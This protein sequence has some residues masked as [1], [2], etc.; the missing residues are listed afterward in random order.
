[1]LVVI[2]D[3]YETPQW[4]LESKWARESGD[5]AS[6]GYVKHSSFVALS[7]HTFLIEPSGFWNL[8]KWGTLARAHTHT[9]TMMSW[10]M[11]L[12][13]ETEKDAVICVC[14]LLIL[15]YCL[16]SPFFLIVWPLGLE[17]R[18]TEFW[19]IQWNVVI[20]NCF[21]LI[22]SPPSKLCIWIALGMGGN[23]ARANIQ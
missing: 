5:F 16:K 21:L 19:E 10:V 23:G 3:T 1:M 13:M 12:I 6:E 20:R 11:Q 2:W 22:F 8:R 17:I 15:F 7:W 9:Y 4:L 14:L 18:W